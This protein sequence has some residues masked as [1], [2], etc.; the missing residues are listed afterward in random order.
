MFILRAEPA[1]IDILNHIPE[2]QKLYLHVFLH[3]DR[4]V[5]LIVR[6]YS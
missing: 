6:E 1:I 5:F 2:E 4:T 3:E